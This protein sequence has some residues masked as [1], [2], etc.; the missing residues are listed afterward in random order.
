MNFNFIYRPHLIVIL[1][2]V[3]LEVLMSNMLF[4]KQYFDSETSKAKEPTIL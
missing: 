1:I 2:K 4:P 3:D